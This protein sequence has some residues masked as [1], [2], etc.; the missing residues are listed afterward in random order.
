[1]TLRSIWAKIFHTS[2]IKVYQMVLGIGS[3]FITTRILGP[4]GR[5]QVAA[6]QSWADLLHAIVSLSVANS[7]FFLLKEKEHDSENRMFGTLIASTVILYG[8]AI[9][10]FLVLYLV[11]P[12]VF[13]DIGFV[14][15]FVGLAGILAYQFWNKVGERLILYFDGIKKLNNIQFVV[16]TLGLLVMFVLVYVLPLHIW[17]YLISLLVPNML[18]GLYIFHMLRKDYELRPI[19][20]RGLTKRAIAVGFSFHL[21][22]IAG[23]LISRTDAIMINYFVG[24][25]DLGLYDLAMRLVGFANVLTQAIYQISYV[26]IAQGDEKESFRVLNKLMLQSFVLLGA[27]IAIGF[28][29][30]PILIRIVAGPEFGASIPFFRMLIWTVIPRNFS[31]FLVVYLVSNGMGKYSSILTVIVSLMNVA[32]NMWLIPIY[33]AIGAVYATLAA[34]FLPLTVK[35]YLYRRITKDLAQ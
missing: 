17:G 9:V 6:V 8:I 28:F 20:D 12:A 2:A 34:Q 29:A 1:V 33:G 3:L 10:V 23:M 21:G 18:I 19:F 32:M 30:A 15:L 24:A 7:I 31:S 25:V 35:F 16:R 14:F 27:I 5:G 4:G 22:S 13:G 26:V 11:V